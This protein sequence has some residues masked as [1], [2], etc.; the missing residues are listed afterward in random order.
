MI[1]NQQ[2]IEKDEN[3][4]LQAYLDMTL[5]LTQEHGKGKWKYVDAEDFFNELKKRK[6][7]AMSVVDESKHSSARDHNN[8]GRGVSN[9]SM[10]NN[11]KTIDY[12]NQF[13]AAPSE[14]NN[15]NNGAGSATEKFMQKQVEKNHASKYSKESHNPAEQPNKSALS[16]KE[17]EGGFAAVLGLPTITVETLYQ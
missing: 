3:K 12:N 4:K 5:R 8:N 6:E 2:R 15:S 10:P 13:N 9:L 11:D 16:H 7:T 14:R 17:S 1:I